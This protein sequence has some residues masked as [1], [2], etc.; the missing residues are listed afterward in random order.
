MYSERS[1]MFLTVTCLIVYHTAQQSCTLFSGWNVSWHQKQASACEG[2]SVIHYQNIPLLC[3]TGCL[4]TAFWLPALSKVRVFDSKPTRAG[5]K[6]ARRQLLQLKQPSFLFGSLL[7]FFCWAFSLSL[8]ISSNSVAISAV[9]H[10]H[11]QCPWHNW[12][13]AKWDGWH[14]PLCLSPIQSGS[15][16]PMWSL[17]LD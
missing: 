13:S 1:F 6:T 12:A 15:Q 10:P 16:T 11:R 7:S 8:S 14:H 17:G 3:H 4:S 9:H 5:Q 2:M